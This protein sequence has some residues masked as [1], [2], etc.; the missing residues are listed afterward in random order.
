MKWSKN[1]NVHIPMRKSIKIM[2]ISYSEQ[3]YN[4]VVCIYENLKKEDWSQDAQYKF[5]S[6]ALVTIRVLISSSGHTEVID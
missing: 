1:C 2:P 6:L 5:W 3:S 4:Q